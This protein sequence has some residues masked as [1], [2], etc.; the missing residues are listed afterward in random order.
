MERLKNVC[1]TLVCSPITSRLDYGNALLYGVNASVLAKL[2]R[3]HNTAA[4]L[5]VVTRNTII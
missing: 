2:Q 3:V 5:I 1:K 4:R